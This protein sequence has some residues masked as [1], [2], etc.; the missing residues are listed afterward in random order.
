VQLGDVVEGLRNLAGLTAPIEGEAHR[1][2]A[3]THRAQRRKQLAFGDGL[4]GG[5]RLF[6]DHHRLLLFISSYD[7]S[8]DERSVRLENAVAIA[9]PTN[10]KCAPCTK[11]Q[12]T[13][14]NRLISAW[15][16]SLNRIRVRI[17]RYIRIA[18]AF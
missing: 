8:P 10:A 6:A 7:T 1:E 4:R 12:G 14:T 15:R 3:S 17:G 9:R 11:V 13:P 5:S 16:R 18:N 2:V